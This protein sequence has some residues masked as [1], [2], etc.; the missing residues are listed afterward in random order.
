M[1]K[2]F[3]VVILAVCLSYGYSEDYTPNELIIKTNQPRLITRNSLGLSSLD[4]YLADK[5]V[6]A[7]T[8]IDGKDSSQYFLVRLAEPV[9]WQ[10][11][12]QFQFEGVEYIEPNYLSE[13]LLYPN[14]PLLYEQYYDLVSV[15]AAWNITIGRDDILVA[16]VDSGT[17]LDH[18][19]LQKNLYINQGEIPVELIS[20]L[21]EN[22][23]KIIICMKGF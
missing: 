8:S 11:I 17:H 18:P 22:A 20:E 19:D 21:D 7:I 5:S 1:K 13:F 6:S 16:V 9:N 4:S 10:E 14:D 15:P 12:G 23:K 2:I 3:L